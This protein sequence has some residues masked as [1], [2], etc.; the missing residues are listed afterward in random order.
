MT[1]YE[2]RCQG[3]CTGLKFKAACVKMNVTYQRRCLKIV[4]IIKK[5]VNNKIFEMCLS[6]CVDLYIFLGVYIKDNL[7]NTSMLTICRVAL[8]KI[9]LNVSQLKQAVFNLLPCLCGV[10]CA[11]ES[12]TKAKFHITTYPLWMSGSVFE[13]TLQ[14]TNIYPTKRD[15]ENHLQ[16]WLLMGYVSCLQGIWWED[17]T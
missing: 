11:S 15:K 17:N 8:F 2:F 13:C 9:S 12:T 16:T 6:C 10:T 14:G 5:L 4:E 1:I 3:S 7:Q